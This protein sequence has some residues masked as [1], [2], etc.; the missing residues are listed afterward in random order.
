MTMHDDHDD[1]GL[2]R[3]GDR[4]LISDRELDALAEAELIWARRERFARWWACGA[5]DSED[6]LAA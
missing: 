6:F 3:A 4:Y 2:E 5:L 1:E